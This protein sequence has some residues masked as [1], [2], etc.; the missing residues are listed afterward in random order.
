MYGYI[1]IYIKGLLGKVRERIERASNYRCVSMVCMYV[2]VYVC[3][4]KGSY[5]CVYVYIFKNL[6]ILA[7][8]SP[9]YMMHTCIHT[10]IFRNLFRNMLPLCNVCI[11]IR[12]YIHTYIRIHMHTYIFK[13]LFTLAVSST[14]YMI[15]T[16]IH[17]YIYFQESFWNLLLLHN[18]YNMHIHAGKQCMHMCI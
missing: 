4:L 15:H 5:V 17:T 6:F 10:Y 3:I 14:V 8:S 12:T 1:C 16:C 13:N 9:V 2:C 18:I 11:I 7:V